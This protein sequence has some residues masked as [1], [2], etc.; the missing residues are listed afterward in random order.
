MSCTVSTKPLD[1]NARRALKG[2]CPEPGGFIPGRGRTVST[3]RV[4][5]FVSPSVLT[6]YNDESE[7]GGEA[8]AHPSRQPTALAYQDMHT[9][10]GCHL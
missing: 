3:S 4:L 9:C 1:R 8:A 6:P 10:A 5:K 7:V 2:Y